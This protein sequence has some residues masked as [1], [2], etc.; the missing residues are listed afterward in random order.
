MRKMKVLLL[1]VCFVALFPIL[2]AAEEIR[3]FVRPFNVVGS[4]AN[5]D[6]NRAL[7]QALL[8]AKLADG[9]ILPVISESDADIIA[10]GTYVSV[11]NQFSLDVVLTDSNNKVLGRRAIQGQTASQSAFAIISLIATDLKPELDKVKSRAVTAKKPE[12]LAKTIDNT[13]GRIK[14][15]DIVYNKD[16]SDKTVQ[17][18]AIPRIQGSFSLMRLLQNEKAFAIADNRTVRIINSGNSK[19]IDSFTLPVGSQIINIDIIESS[20]STDDIFVTYIELNKVY[21]SIY[22]F[23][24]KQSRRTGK[25]PYFSRVVRLQG[26]EPR[27]FIQEQGVESS[28][29]YGP[30]FEAKWGGSKIVKGAVFS[31][32]DN[33]DIYSF[34]QFVDQ[35][36]LIMTVLFDENGYLV[37]Y[38]M[39][40][41][42]V[43]K[44]ND[45]FG[46]SELS[47]LI[48]D[49]NYINK[50]GKE[51]RTY[52]MHQ[53]IEVTPSQSI[54]VGHNDGSFVIG[55]ARSYKKGAVY[56]FLWNGSSLEE[57]WHTRETQ[58]YMP[59]FEYSDSTKQLYQLQLVSR[60]N[61]FNATPGISSIIVKKVE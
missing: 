25:E 32:P 31:L 4:N 61:P 33:A 36:G 49:L 41:D 24:G 45:K 1:M 27:L 20:G 39:K 9:N 44:S 55:D 17:S 56:N 40:M 18:V 53:K 58:S 57:A 16:T 46:G 48:H 10:Q 22:R 21:T 34:N 19:E 6:E 42:K 38:D 52:F 28:R 43:W 50:T 51:F 15:K 13:S 23:D 7:L 11:A 3:I 26:K 5:R 54:L 8:T 30:V 59:D 29:Y 37:V 2:G 35:S 60:E 14:S 47:Y 12:P